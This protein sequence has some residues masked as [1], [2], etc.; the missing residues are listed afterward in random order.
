MNYSFLLLLLDSYFII[1]LQLKAKNNDIQEKCDTC[2]TLVDK[3]TQ[4][5]ERTKK[6]N[7][8]GGNTGNLTYSAILK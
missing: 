6:G 2:K 8:G 7:F 4:E 5:L 1:S 3:F